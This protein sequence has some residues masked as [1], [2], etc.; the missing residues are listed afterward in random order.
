MQK[1]IKS[2]M[3][4]SLIWISQEDFSMQNKHIMYNDYI[5]KNMQNHVLLNPYRLPLYKNKTFYAK[6][7]NI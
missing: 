7:A 6:K 3:L 4:I 2:K 1:N 5:I